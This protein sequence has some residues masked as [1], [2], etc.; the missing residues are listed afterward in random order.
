MFIIKACWGDAAKMNFTREEFLLKTD[1]NKK[2]LPG[3]GEGSGCCIFLL[4]TVPLQWL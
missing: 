1:S 4:I 2:A 3:G